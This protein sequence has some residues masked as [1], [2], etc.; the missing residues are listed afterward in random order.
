MTDILCE[1][2]K[3]FVFDDEEECYVCDVNLDEDDMMRLLSSKY[4]KCPY[5]Q[6]GD[7]YAIVRK[8]N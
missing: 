4:K 7:D 5:F 1:Q 3:N 8:Q 2:C 6:N